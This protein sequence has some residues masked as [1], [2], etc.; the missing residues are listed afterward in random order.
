MQQLHRMLSLIMTEVQLQPINTF[1]LSDSSRLNLRLFSQ[2][3][4]DLVQIVSK[5]CFCLKGNTHQVISIMYNIS[6]YFHY[7]QTPDLGLSGAY[8][9]IPAVF[10]RPHFPVSHLLYTQLLICPF[11]LTSICSLCYY[12]NFCGFKCGVF[13]HEIKTRRCFHKVL[14]VHSSILWIKIKFCVK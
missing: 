14:Q 2:I 11:F 8:F 12:A 3:L 4:L 1:I 10:Q 6:N 5:S 7:G 9:V 13:N